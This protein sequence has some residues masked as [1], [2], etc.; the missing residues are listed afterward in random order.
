MTPAEARVLELYRALNGRDFDGFFSM[1]S[2]H[3]DWTND[4][5]DS[6]LSGK[7][8]VRAHILDETVLMRAEFAPIHV[9]TLSDGRVSA[10]V[11]QTILGATD[12]SVCSDTRVRHTFRLED[13]LVARMD[14]ERAVH[15][16]DADV[17]PLLTSL[18]AAIERQ[19]VDAVLALF[20]RDARIPDSLEQAALVGRDQIRAYYQRQFA[21]IRVGSSLLATNPL[22][23]GRIE[24]FLHV[25][26][27]GSTGGFWWEGRVTA[28]YR[29]EG[30]LI[31][32][33]VVTEPPGS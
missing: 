22:P 27:Q 9:H 10:L 28:T 7:D 32:E 31:T 15:A 18:Y 25:L 24:A 16:V 14:S 12:G 6:R 17:E 5:D 21:A 1:L 3:V 23:D 19:D 29:I 11:Q 2:P 8:A 13:G 30:G 26:V 4:T 20:H 33:M